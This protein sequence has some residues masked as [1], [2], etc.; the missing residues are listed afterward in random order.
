MPSDIATQAAPARSWTRATVFLALV[1]V[2]ATLYWLVGDRLELSRIARYEASLRSYI[3]H[4]PV[5]VYVG[6]F[7]LYVAVTGLLLPGATALT[8]L[9]GWLF[10][11]WRAV[12][13]VSFAS[14]AGA[15]AACLLSRYLVRDTVERWM[16]PRLDA[17]HRLWK[18]DGVLSLF[19][20]RLL[21]I[22]P[23]FVVNVAAGV[24]PVRVRTFWWVSQLGMLPGTMVYVYAGSVVPDLQ[25]LAKQGARGVFTPKVVF[26]FAALGLF[27]LVV[28]LLVRRWSTK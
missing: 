2:I 11:F 28:R 3:E 18:R 19:L 23:F 1:I 4:H 26:A 27:S 9:F 14:T 12:V 15:T 24:T 10:G 22:F 7:L 16:G 8:L 6:A 13:I 25:V 21:P 5:L 20:V 17:F